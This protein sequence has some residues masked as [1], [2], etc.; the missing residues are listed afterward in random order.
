[1]SRPIRR[2]A[3]APSI[4]RRARSSSWIESHAAGVGVVG[5]AWAGPTF[6]WGAAMVMMWECAGE[7]GGRGVQR[8]RPLAGLLGVAARA[9]EGIERRLR[10]CELRRGRTLRRDRAAEEGG[11]VGRAPA[12]PGA[13]REPGGAIGGDR[14]LVERAAI[15]GG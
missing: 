5:R 1:M 8:R 15:A 3:V 2:V 7:G 13:G 10:R 14:G 11:L 9:L 12:G 4:G 6:A